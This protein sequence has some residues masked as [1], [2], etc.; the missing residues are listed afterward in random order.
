MTTLTV[1]QGSRGVPTLVTLRQT[2]VDD[3]RDELAALLAEGRELA[4]ELVTVSRAAQVRLARGQSPADLLDRLERLGTRHAARMA[5][6]AVE[7]HQGELC[8]DG[9]TVRHL[10]HGRAA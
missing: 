6:A 2:E 7:S 3:M 9:Q 4:G 5:A 1:I 8:P 10:G